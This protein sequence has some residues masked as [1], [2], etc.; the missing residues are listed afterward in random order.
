MARGGILYGIGG[1]V[2]GLVIGFMIANSINRTA[3]VAENKP[4]STV[5]EAPANMNF[6][7]D[8]PLAASGGQTGGGALPQVTE[9]IERAKNEPNSF[10]AQMTAGDLYYRIQRF[11]DAAKFYEKANQIKPAELEAML[12]LGN[13][14]F[15]AEQYESAEKWYLEVLKKT[16][17]DT[18]V[19][20]DLGLTYYLR[21]PRDIERAVREFQDALVVEPNKEITLQNLALAYRE[22]GDD[23]N[24]AKTLETLKKVNPNNPVV[25]RSAAP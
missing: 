3:S 11:A 16:P 15:D 13:A 24:F 23:A 5:S 17:N 18:S 25:T 10:E 9:A 4:S 1:L 19:R 20:T 14:Y 21:T 7:A 2:V 22:S 8:H 6:P 12:K